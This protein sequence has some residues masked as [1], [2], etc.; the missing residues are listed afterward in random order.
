[1]VFNTSMK[2]ETNPAARKEQTMDKS[3]KE[4]VK[5]LVAKDGGDKEKC[6]RWM[7]RNMPFGIREARKVIKEATA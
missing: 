3:T 4:F 2:T 6:A 1:M 5:S 7:A